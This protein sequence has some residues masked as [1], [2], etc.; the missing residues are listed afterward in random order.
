[1]ERPLWTRLCL[2]LIVSWTAQVS[3]AAA[4]T[5]QQCIDTALT[6]SVKLQA[7]ENEAL[8]AR[9]SYEQAW[10]RIAPGVSGSASQSWSFG[11]STGVDNIT[12]ARN[13]ATTNMGVNASWTLF[14]GLAMV[15][16]IEQAK[17][18]WRAGKADVEAMQRTISVNV[19]GLFLQVLL[20]K[21]LTAVA[22]G[23]LEDIDRKVERA[24]ALVESGRLAEG[25]LFS[26]QSQQ[27]KERYAVTQNR[28]KIQLA[29]LDLA[30]AMEIEYSTDFDIVTPSEE[31]MEERLLPD[32]EEVY[33]TALAQRPEMAAAQYRLYAQERALK[34]AKSAYS[35]TLTA[36]GGVNTGYYHLYGEDNASFGKQLHDNLSTNVGLTLSVPIFDRMQTPSAVRKQKLAVANAKLN[37]EQVKKDLRKEIDQAYYNAV[38]AQAEQVS[39]QQAARSASEAQRYASEKFDNGRGTPY[40][41]YDAQQTYLQAQS[42]L[43]QARYNYLFKVRILE[44]YMG[45]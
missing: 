13:T 31:S 14:D 37:I 17:A 45:L 12:R 7:Q 44:Y 26:L 34:G 3:D 18:S 36:Q 20:A 1:M 15:F 25:E 41:Y 22:E 9:A 6:N 35:P 2:L 11:R 4:Y 38:A 43:L 19:T 8:S 40:E 30:Q 32:R 5:L 29:L 33:Q 16:N 23:Q 42:E 24:E 21:E 27:A 10:G 28:N 39:A